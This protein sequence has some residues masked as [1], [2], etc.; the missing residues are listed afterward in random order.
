MSKLIKKFLIVALVVALAFSFVACDVGYHLCNLNI[1]VANVELINY[2]NPAAQ[3]SPLEKHPLDLEK[4][5][6]LETLGS[7]S[8]DN[9][10]NELSK[11][12]KYLGGKFK[13]V[14][15][16]PAGIGVRIIY[17]DGSFTLITVTVI[18]GKD[19]IFRGDYDTIYNIGYTFGIAWQEMI[20][21]FKAVVN[22]YFETQV[23]W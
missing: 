19:S 2:N 18:K 14:L 15:N 10:I 20:D 1:E 16:S 17:Q 21:G 13:Q 8:R 6:T 22:K 3:N 12:G 7:D 4:L 9:F 5:E 11:I 23:N